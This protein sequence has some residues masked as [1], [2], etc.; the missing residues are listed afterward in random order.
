MA[1]VALPASK[2]LAVRVSFKWH[3]AVAAVLLGAMALVTFAVA[4]APPQEPAA[5]TPTT[6][7]PESPPSAT[8]TPNSAPA[9]APEASPAAPPAAPAVDYGGDRAAAYKAFREHFDA[10]RFAEAM[11][12]AQQ[13]VDIS[14]Q[15]YGRDAPEMV[16]PLM[17]LGTTKQRLSDYNG[18]AVQYQRALKLIESH[19]GGFSRDII[20]PLLG[21]GV[22]YAA[23]GDYDASARSLRRAVDVSRKLDGL[24]NPQ[25]LELVEPLV[26]SYVA[27]G[28]YE[29]AV[30]EQQYALRLAEST[31]G[32]SDPRLLPALEHSAQWLETTGQYSSARQAYAR[33]LDIARK[34][35]GKNDLRM[36]VPL[37]GIARMYRMEYL[38]GSGPVGDPDVPPSPQTGSPVYSGPTPGASPVTTVLND[39]GEDALKLALEVLDDHPEEAVALRGE[40][41]VDLGD[42]YMIA[43]R[44][45]DAMH[46]YKEAWAALSVPGAT[47]TKILDTPIQ[48]IYRPPSSGK[49]NPTVDPE[50]YTEHFVEAEFT[51]TPE[52]R[53]KDPKVV[54]E[55]VSESTGKSVLTS[56]RRSRYRPRFVDGGPVTTSGVRHRQVIFVRSS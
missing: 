5:P 7:T 34:S 55:D 15:K 21:L 8:A 28:Q 6:T 29:E 38:H 53:A 9:A 41:L 23:A 16:T 40:T 18:A 45:R 56:I 50:E 35:G 12:A 13:V 10:R 3:V 48:L 2:T 24:F 20:P 49:R 4:Q 22:S 51:V 32:R 31:Y 46:E 14:E 44:T 17:N 19:Q 33:A 27:L 43:G 25:Q 42:W 39:A 26:A 1:G 52:G 54:A 11:P 37:R 36:V 47:G 30:R